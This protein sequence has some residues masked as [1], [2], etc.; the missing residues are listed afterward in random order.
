MLLR[1]KCDGAF[2]ARLEHRRSRMAL[3]ELAPALAV[4]AARDRSELARISQQ[5]GG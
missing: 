1:R 4:V 3:L 2:V 5:S